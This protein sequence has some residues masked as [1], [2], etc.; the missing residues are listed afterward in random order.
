MQRDNEAITVQISPI[1]KTHNIINR[2][3][4]ARVL[5][6]PKRVLPIKTEANS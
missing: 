5:A 4:T 2:S 3:I 6:V 1:S